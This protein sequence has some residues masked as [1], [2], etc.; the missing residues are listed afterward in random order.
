MVTVAIVADTHIPSR[1]SGIPEWV[2]T[3]IEAADHVVHAGDFD[4]AEAY[5]TV[6]ELSAELT[7]VTG[8]MDPHGL[9][10]PA[11]TTLSIGGVSFVVTHG[12]GPVENYRERVAATVREHDADAIGIA[13]HTHEVLDETVDGTRLLNPGSATGAAPA[14]EATMYVATIADGALDVAL[15]EG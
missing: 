3:E 10:L 1:A 13:G 7:A 4:S 6:T 15:R 11:V 2:Q 5:E 8:N 14:S 9:D 12:T